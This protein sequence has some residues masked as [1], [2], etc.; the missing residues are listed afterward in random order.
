MSSSPDDDPRRRRLRHAR[1]GP[2][3][4]AR[5]DG[6]CGLHQ[7]PASFIIASSSSSNSRV[8]E[9][10][11]ATT[12]AKNGCGTGEV[13]GGLVVLRVVLDAEVDP[14]HALGG[15]RASVRLGGPVVLRPVGV[16]VVAEL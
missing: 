15:E 1:P 3:A 6:D 10:T 14:G 7:R 16:G 9:T 13:V 12:P 4:D 11:R 2:R 8:A 5:G